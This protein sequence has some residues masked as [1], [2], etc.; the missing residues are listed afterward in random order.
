MSYLPSKKVAPIVVASLLAL[1][2]V[3]AAS[4]YKAKGPKKADPKDVFA[5]NEVAI[6]PSV[7]TK[8]AELDVDKDGLKDWEEQM[9]GTDPTKADTDGDGTTDGEEIRQGR[10]PR[11]AGPKDSLASET[12]AAGGASGPAKPETQTDIIAQQF[13]AEFVAMKRSGQT[14][15]DEQQQ[16]LIQ[17]LVEQGSSAVELPKTYIYS[18]IRIIASSPEALRM[19]GNA[20]AIAIS[21]NN[22][23]QDAENELAI[24]EEA[25]NRQDPALLAGLDPAI[26]AYQNI[27]RDL[28]AV[29]VPESAAPSHLRLVNGFSNAITRIKAFRNVF[30][31]PALALSSI[32]RYLDSSSDIMEGIRGI[33]RTITDAGVRYAVDE[34]GYGLV[35]LG[36]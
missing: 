14:I 32:E 2:G 24:L 30:K 15:T 20:V 22:T 1:V 33:S 12:P 5:T 34:P 21:K 35:L 36:V 28:L 29:K 8:I 26:A 4:T 16:R 18:D 13:F 9:A 25:V 17:R 10:D 19:Y 3:V 31:D 11:K 23:L 27:V 7:E 6:A